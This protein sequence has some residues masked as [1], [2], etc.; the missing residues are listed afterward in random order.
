VATALSNPRVGRK[1]NFGQPP[2]TTWTL[3]SSATSVYYA[4]YMMKDGGASKGSVL[5]SAGDYANFIGILDQDM[6]CA[7]TSAAA[8]RGATLLDTDVDNTIPQT[9]IQEI[10]APAVK[11][12]GT[13][14][15]K[16][17]YVQ[18]TNAY[19]VASAASITSAV[20][21]VASAT[22]AAGTRI[23]IHFKAQKWC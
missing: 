5:A 1:S 19:T 10:T 16:G 15:L 12:S 8:D 14:F 6:P 13:A 18:A 11:V 9:I 22:P 7:I 4:G 3:T 21:T 23:L 17:A 2:I 20:G